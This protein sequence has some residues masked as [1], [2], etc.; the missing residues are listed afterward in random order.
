MVL[1]FIKPAGFFSGSIW[2]HMILIEMAQFFQFDCWID[3][4]LPQLLLHPSTLL[5]DLPVYLLL[6]PFV[7]LLVVGL[8][9]PVHSVVAFFL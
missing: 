8:Q 7:L 6:L 2:L 5:L 9:E 1:F 3:S 4:G